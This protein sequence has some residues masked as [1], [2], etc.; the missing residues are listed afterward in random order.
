[1]FLN[2]F[3]GDYKN[4]NLI[5]SAFFGQERCTHGRKL[6]PVNNLFLFL[7][8]FFLNPVFIQTLFILTLSKIQI[9]QLRTVKNNN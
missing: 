7:H 4:V 5:L 2:V 8:I 3:C 9:G 1:M 6:C